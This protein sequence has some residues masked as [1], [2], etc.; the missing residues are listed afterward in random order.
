MGLWEDLGSALKGIAEFA[1]NPVGKV[2]QMTGD[3]VGGDTGKQ[4][5]D[6]SR[7][8]SYI[9]NPAAFMSDTL[10]GTSGGGVNESA[11]YVGEGVGGN[12]GQDIKNA[13]KTVSTGLQLI[14]LL[15]PNN[16]MYMGQNYGDIAK[17]TAGKIGEGFNY[18]SNPGGG[19]INELGTM[20]DINPTGGTTY[21]EP[22]INETW[23]DRVYDASKSDISF[24]D[25]GKVDWGEIGKTAWDVSQNPLVNTGAQYLMQKDLNKDNAKAQQGYQ[26]G[27]QLGSSKGTVFGQYT[28]PGWKPLKSAHGLNTL[29]ELLNAGGLYA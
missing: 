6:I 4:I 21:V 28:D 24:P 18:L 22:K 16:P 23:Q 15:D 1:T 13:G 27:S 20:S 9:T 3:F 11:R 5:R 14:N 7:I 19:P 29:S 2:G 17:N 8:V 10:L 25:L 26:S 12:T